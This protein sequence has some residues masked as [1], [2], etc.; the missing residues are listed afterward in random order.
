MPQGDGLYCTKLAMKKTQCDSDS[1]E[2]LK[3]LCVWLKFD[4]KTV[5]VL[6]YNL[7]CTAVWVYVCVFGV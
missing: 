6:I 7:Q 4:V 2:I 5:K 1:D 3:R